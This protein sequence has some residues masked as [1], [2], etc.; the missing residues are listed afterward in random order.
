MPALRVG[1]DGGHRKRQGAAALRDL[2]ESVASGM[3]C[4]RDNGSH[5]VLGDDR[6]MMSP[7]WGSIRGEDAGYNEAGPTGL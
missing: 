3:E 5:M 6:R 4:R 7:R 2:S 1:N